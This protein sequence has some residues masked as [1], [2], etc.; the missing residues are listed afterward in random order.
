[1]Q[2][3]ADQFFANMIATGAIVAG[4]APSFF[5][6]QFKEKRNFIISLTNP[7]KLDAGNG[8]RDEITHM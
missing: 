4:F 2:N 7:S 5:N 1:M 3:P 8:K 6:S